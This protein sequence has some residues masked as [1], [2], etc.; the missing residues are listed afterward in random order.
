MILG[1]VAARALAI[2]ASDWIG[3]GET[4]KVQ[5]AG[6]ATVYCRAMKLSKYER[7]RVTVALRDT[8]ATGFANDSIAV[9]VKYRTFHQ[10]YNAN[11][12]VDSCVTP[13]V[14]IDT[15]NSL[16]AMTEGSICDPKDTVWLPLRLPRRA[17]KLSDTTVCTGYAVFS[18]WF[19]PE[20]D[21]FIQIVLVGLGD[22]DKTGPIG[23]VQ[24]SKR[25]FLQMREYKE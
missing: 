12:V 11:G 21:Q 9:V 7:I 13:T 3:L 6:T 19:T 25:P 24:L 16:G 10:C 15:M 8:S 22:N 4:A 2:D 18:R 20:W 23:Y 14:V 5:V 1:M 17:N